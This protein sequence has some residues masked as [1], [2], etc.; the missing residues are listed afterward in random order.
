MLKYIPEA[1][2]QQFPVHLTVYHP[3]HSIIHYLGH[4]NMTTTSTGSEQN[5]I[6]SP[7]ILFLLPYLP[8]TTTCHKELTSKMILQN[9]FTSKAIFIVMQIPSAQDT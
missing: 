9:H 2:N 8:N 5:I 3:L 6:V 7:I 1:V 4:C